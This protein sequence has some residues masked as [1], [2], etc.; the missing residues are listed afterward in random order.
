MRKTDSSIVRIARIVYNIF[1]IINGIFMPYFLNTDALNWGGKT[2]L[3]WAGMCCICLLWTYFRVPEP[4]GR[5]YGQSS[6]PPHTSLAPS[7]SSITISPP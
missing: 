3:F 6:T 4:K 1:G 2:G 5:T 7:P